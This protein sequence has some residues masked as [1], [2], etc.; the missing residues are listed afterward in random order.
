MSNHHLLRRCAGLNGCWL[1]YD[2]VLA[3]SSLSQIVS[4][5]SALLGVMD[6]GGWVHPWH[7]Q[8]ALSSHAN[9]L[10][11]RVLNKPCSSG[12][13]WPCGFREA[14]QEVRDFWTST[15]HSRN[16]SPIHPAGL[17]QTVMF[18]RRRQILWN[19]SIIFLNN[20]FWNNDKFEITSDLN[21]DSCNGRMR[22]LCCAFDPLDIFQ[23]ML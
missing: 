19:L 17:R 8:S 13:V 14:G 11:A 6:Q 20:V 22:V 4:L 5:S 1:V 2:L 3:L 18:W 9:C 23:K 15:R 12:V 16:T 21:I 10:Q 7:V